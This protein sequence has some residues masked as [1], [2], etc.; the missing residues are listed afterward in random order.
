MKYSLRPYQED[1]INKMVWA[2]SLDG[3]DLVV[4]AQGAGKSI[5]IAE[6]SSR[7]DD[8]ILVLVPSKELLEQNLEKL[9]AVLDEPVAVYSASMNSKDVGKITIAT[10]QSA[11]KRPD[12]F[13]HIGVVLLDECDLLNPKREGMYQKLF[14]GA[15]VR[16]VF[17]LTATPYRLDTYYH[18]P[19]GWSGYG[20]RRKW[21]K[22]DLEAITCLKMV[23]RYKPPFFWNRMLYVL[24]THE[25]QEQG[26]LTRLTYHDMTLIEHDMLPINKSES[27]FDIEA[28]DELTCNDYIKVSEFIG[29]LKHERI[30]VFCS[31]IAQ[32][33][34]LNRLIDGSV[35][36][37]SETKKKDRKQAISDFRSG[38]VKVLL[39]V[40]IFVVGFDVPELDSIVSLRPTKSLRVWSQLLGRG[41]RIADGK[42]TCHV[43]DFAGNVRGLGTLESTKVTKVDGKWDVVTDVFTGGMHKEPLYSHKIERKNDR[44]SRVSNDSKQD[45]WG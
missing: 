15:G 38:K 1:A 24:N 3:N 32:A 21:E 5:V 16:K 7:I 27:D 29:S 13:E 42:K 2:N 9:N 41:A 17:G 20:K 12:L 8:N 14:T 33:E 28:F 45:I 39:G 18:N 34:A 6:L 25:L 30:L 44:P 35:V 22:Y 19:N 23:N 31:S 10:I 37:T 4:M 36:V 26:Y 11:Y 43:Y 40:M